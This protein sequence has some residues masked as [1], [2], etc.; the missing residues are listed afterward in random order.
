MAIPS[1][2]KPY[3]NLLVPTQSTVSVNRL[4]YITNAAEAQ[5]VCGALQ[6][7][8][9]TAMQSETYHKAFY[10]PQKAFHIKKCLLYKHRATQNP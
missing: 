2:A 7:P 8:C 9:T 1:T 10:M 5:T 3:Y 6:N 4:I